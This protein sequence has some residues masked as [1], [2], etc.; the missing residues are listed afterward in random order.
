MVKVR[1]G[2]MNILDN[3]QYR[4]DLEVTCRNLKLDSIANSRVM[5]T[6]ALGLIGSS[7]VDLLISDNIIHGHKTE[8]LAAARSKER[9][10]QRYGAYSFVK[11][12]P[13]DALKPLRLDCHP[14]YIIHCAGISN[15]EDYTGKPVETLLSNFK[16]ISDILEYSHANAVKR[17]LYVSSSEVYGKKEFED[18]FLEGNYGR[19]DIDNIRNS[20]PVAKVSSE[21]L[22]KAYCSEYGT[23]TVIVRPGHIYGP[24]ATDKDKRVVSDFTHKAANGIDLE[25]KS[26]GLQKRSYCYSLNAALAILI[27]LQNGK[28]GEVY[29]IANDEVTTIKEMAEM[30]ARTGQ[31][32][33]SC[34]LPTAEELRSFNPMNNSSLNNQKIKDLGYQDVFTVQEGL[35]HTV[36]ILKS[37]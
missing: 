11:F 12:V 22:C 20:Y 34:V 9:F 4:Y 37:L 13:Y 2:A 19:I 29:N 27:V 1:V 24:T 23:D 31:V 32:R 35:E 18:A 36:E 14:D 8:I 16:G 7:L 26:A 30:V 10:A 6:G 28:A 25:M 15:P 21:M 33:L 5:I 17:V 3:E